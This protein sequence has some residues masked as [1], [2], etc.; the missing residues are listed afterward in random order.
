MSNHTPGP[1]R[2][3]DTVSSDR[4][5]VFGGEGENFT[6]IG[7]LVSGSIKNLKTFK[8]NIQLIS[9]APELLGA[10]EYLLR[11]TDEQ[12]CCNGNDCGCR[13][14]TQRAEAEH[15]AQAAIKKANKKAKPLD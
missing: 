13:G 15:I 12:L 9:A 8:A 7:T 10:L 5:H 4:K 11:A 3:E 1:W 14:A 6:H 2:I